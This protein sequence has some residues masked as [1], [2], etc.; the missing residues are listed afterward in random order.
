[1]AA[2][3]WLCF[4][5]GNA[6]MAEVYPQSLP[7]NRMA[8]G[9]YA[10]RNLGLGGPRFADPNLYNLFDQGG[11]PL[12]LL[13]TR[14]ERLSV[15]LQ[16]WNSGRS[17]PG[18]SLQIA[19]GD[20]IIPQVGFSQPDVF[21]AVLYFHRES[22]SYESGLG[23]SLETGK[24]R[25]GLDLAAG[26]A[27]GIFRIGFGA[28]AAL[29]S[30]EYPGSPERVL[31]DIPSL[32]L[33]VGSRLLPW[34]ELGAFAGVSVHF[35]SLDK[36]TNQLERAA[37]MTLPR[38]GFLADVGDIPGIPLRGN[39][40][41]EF[42]TRRFFG[43]YRSGNSP[44]QTYPTIWTGYWQWQSQFLYLAEIRDFR[45]GP[46]L[47]FAHRSEDAQGYQGI[48]SNQ[49]P[50]RKGD[51][52]DTLAWD[53]GVT[54]FGLGANLAFREIVSLLLEWE[55]AG[56]SHDR[57][58]TIEKRYH[59]FVL[60]AEHRLDQI[61]ALRFPEGLHLALRAGWSWRQEEK[62]RPGIQPFHFDPFVPRV[63]VPT[64]LGEILSVP[65]DPA[66]IGAFQMGFTL[67]LLGDRIGLDALLSFP[68]QL[69]RYGNRTQDVSGVE[70]GLA[71]RYRLP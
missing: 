35:D 53:R 69:E 48:I 52:I 28:H 15:S 55:T 22:E 38:F 58:T 21:A 57:D 1:M 26:P 18:D 60:G 42:G 39:L 63:A 6:A 24:T 20:W 45:L 14:R 43:E 41:L 46:A 67:G 71:G 65:D 50:L 61:P 37:D 62:G 7:A 54:A 19:H 66:G 31:I 59:R 9:P 2:L 56:H 11:S 8:A 10:M 25:F 44:G 29:G 47:R 4:L 5:S 32:R 68:G 49:N 64:R 30:M 36:A 33:D 17:G 70:F 27:S 13:E 3:T 16:T 34:L 51:K 12:G 40:G 23:D